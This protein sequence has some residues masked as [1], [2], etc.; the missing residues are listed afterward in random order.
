[1][2][3]PAAPRHRI[4][5]GHGLAVRDLRVGALAVDGCEVDARA[6]GTGIADA[7]VTG[8]IAGGLAVRGGVVDADGTTAM[9]VV[10]EPESATVPVGET[11]TPSG[12]P[13]ADIDPAI[14]GAVT[15]Q[16][17]HPT[18]KPAVRTKTTTTTAAT[19]TTVAKA[20]NH[21]SATA[22]SSSLPKTADSHW[23]AVSAVL[24]LLGTALLAV[25]RRC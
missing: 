22:T 17:T 10:I 2:G 19:K 14:G 4:A 5:D 24:F 18:V 13:S 9:H 6:D 1:M 3:R 7:R 16:A 15:E 20:S 8:V 12:E 23:A 21:K 25:A 11:D